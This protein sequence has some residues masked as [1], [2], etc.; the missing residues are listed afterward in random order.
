MYAAGKKS[1]QNLSALTRR[2]ETSGLEG[3]RVKR[4]Y[5]KIIRGGERIERERELRL[6]RVSRF[7]STRYRKV[8]NTI[9]TISTASPFDVILV[10]WLFFHDANT[11]ENP[12]HR[13]SRNERNVDA[14]SN[15]LRVKP[16]LIKIIRARDGSIPGSGV[17]DPV[18]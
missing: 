8:V 15:S 16:A 4:V 1:C 13:Y 7:A 17:H 5:S 12:D 6:T 3:T 11:I 14:L 10:L 2:G 9:G 18:C